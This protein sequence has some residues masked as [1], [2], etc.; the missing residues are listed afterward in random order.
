MALSSSVLSSFNQLGSATLPLTGKSPVLHKVPQLAN[1]CV[2]CQLESMLMLGHALWSSSEEP[3]AW[4]RGGEA[5][6][7]EGWG[8]GGGGWNGIVEWQRK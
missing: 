4:L 3:E 2:F 8:W 5:N 6:L 7:G 1:V